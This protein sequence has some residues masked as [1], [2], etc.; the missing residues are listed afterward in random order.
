MCRFVRSLTRRGSVATGAARAIGAATMLLAASAPA[1]AADDAPWLWVAPGLY[2]LERTA[3]APADRGAALTAVIHPQLC[4]FFRA[5]NPYSR[6]FSALVK[7]NFANVEDVFGAHLGDGVSAAVQIRG[8]LVVSLRVSRATYE[9]VRRLASVDVFAPVTMTLEITSIATGEVVFTKTVTDVRQGSFSG[10]Q[11]AGEVTR[12]FDTHLRSV[13]ETLVKEAAA[14]FRPQRQ[15]IPIVSATNIPGE[16]KVHIGA[17]GRVAGLKTG[18]TLGLDARVLFAGPDYVV[19]KAPPGSLNVGDSLSRFV[20]TP[21][22]MLNRPTV[23]SVMETVP[24]GY[25]ALYLEQLFQDAISDGGILSPTPVNPSFTLIREDAIGASASTQ[26]IDS[27]SLPDYIAVIKVALLPDAEFPSNVPSVSYARFEAIVLVELVDNAGRILD[28]W[29]GKAAIE[30]TVA[31]T[32]RLSTFQRR[33][34]VVRN[35]IKDVAVQMASFKPRPF[36]VPLRSRQN[37]FE[38]DDPTGAIMLNATLPVLR[39]LGRVPGIKSQ[40]V[41]IPVGLVNP[42]EAQGGIVVAGDAGVADLNVRNGDLV[43]FEMAGMPVLNRSLLGQCVGNDGRLRGEARG[44]V[45]VSVGFDIL[46]N[47]VAKN[48]V[49]PA[50]LTGLSALLSRYQDSFSAWDKLAAAK[51]RAFDACYVPVVVG[52]SSPAGSGVTLAAGY[53]IRRG[54]IVLGA[55]GSQTGVTPTRLP[56][57]ASQ[58][59]RQA[60]LQSD[61][62]KFLP[63]LAAT[64]AKKI[65]LKK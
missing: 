4:D 61:L 12:Q 43:A 41:L 47:A 64:A 24:D 63:M 36:Q 30:D 48:G 23:L 39:R 33:D 54:D 27:R 6:H 38:I 15:P 29:I 19:V 20:S 3:C 62:A 55:G 7:Q 50:G 52:Q 58:A 9:M 5:G 11:V 25:S 28:T 10:N 2:G 22:Q 59:A 31:G 40:D 46:R 42:V 17:A 44:D 57:S 21:A 51:A 37:R 35:A 32:N 56:D 18:D 60:V 8:T 13:I 45:Q 49:W 65:T 53:T 34:A 26:T 16:G 14:T 1:A